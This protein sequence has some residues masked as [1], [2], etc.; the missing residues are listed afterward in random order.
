MV[1][2]EFLSRN[3]TLA[4]DLSNML[5]GGSSHTDPR[6]GGGSERV[7]IDI[8][9]IPTVAWKK[10]TSLVMEITSLESGGIQTCS[11]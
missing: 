8:Y 1:V 9:Q 6:P 2:K 3:A 10:Q 4:E 5:G 11:K 7:P